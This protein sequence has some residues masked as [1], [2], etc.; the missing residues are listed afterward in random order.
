MGVTITV[1]EATYLKLL[2]FRGSPDETEDE[3]IAELLMMVG[4]TDEDI[5]DEETE[6]MIEAGLEDVRAGRYRPLRDIAKDMG[7]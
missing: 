2:S 5:P 7:I 3:I 4:D 1:S 6:Q